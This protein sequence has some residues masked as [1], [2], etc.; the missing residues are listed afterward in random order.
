MAKSKLEARARFDHLSFDKDTMYLIIENK[1]KNEEIWELSKAYPIKDKMIS[2]D[3]FNE[4]SRYQYLGI[5][6]KWDI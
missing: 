2:A 3:I 5:D 4:I 1:M 6:I